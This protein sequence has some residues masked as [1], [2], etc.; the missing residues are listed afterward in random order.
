MKPDLT[1]RTLLGG[2]GALL[3]RPSLSAGTRAA[4]H[5]Y[6]DIK[7]AVATY[8]LRKF[9]RKDAIEII[10]KLGIQ[11]ANVKSFHMPYD[12]SPQQLR[13]ARQ[14]F[15]DAGI[16]VV[17][18]G[19]IPM[20]K[21]D[22]EEVRRLFEYAKHAGMKVMVIAP[23]PEVLPIIERFVKEYDIKVAIH[24]HGPE[25]RYFPAPQDALKL[26]Q[27]MDQR[28]GLCVDVGH[29]IRA[30]VDIL[31]TI[32]VS[33]DRMYDMHIKDLKSFTDRRSQV[34]VGDGKIP[35][36][37][38]LK[39]LREKNYRYTVSLEYEID[40]EDPRI[41]MGRSIGYLRGVLDALPA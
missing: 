14:E 8:S 23:A 30:G 38:I 19:T 34:P 31:E 24:N 25:D 6:D 9:S 2:I 10:R 15:A 41:G 16:E 27:N 18:G 5:R 32:D 35:I 1:R 22:E 11:Y 40:P 20:R 12:L 28:M 33:F 17:A 4:T 29:A 39:K 37:D 3:A 13:A 7:L 21:K 36:V 26:I